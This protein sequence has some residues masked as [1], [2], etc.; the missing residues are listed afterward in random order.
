[1][2]ETDYFSYLSKLKNIDLLL[3]HETTAIIANGAKLIG[4]DK[5]FT[6]CQK[7]FKT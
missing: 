1:M 6:H 5:L 3:T 4:N 2:S 7:Y